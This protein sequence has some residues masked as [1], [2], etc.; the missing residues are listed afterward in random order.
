MKN[1]ISDFYTFFFYN[2]GG[3]SYDSH[4]LENKNYKSLKYNF[5]FDAARCASFIIYGIYRPNKK[6]SFKSG[7]IYR[8]DAYC[9][10]NDFLIR[11]FFSCD[12]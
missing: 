3:L 12:F 11:K 2:Y 10:D 5:S 6:K 9:S 1:Y 7:Q 4:N 8:K